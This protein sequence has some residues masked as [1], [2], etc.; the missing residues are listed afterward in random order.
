MKKVYLISI[1]LLSSWLSFAQNK[2]AEV[3]YDIYAEPFEM[4][5][6]HADYYAILHK[7]YK[8]CEK[9]AYT[10]FTSD[11][12]YLLT[13]VA[14]SGLE[15]PPALK[16]VSSTESF[17]L[18]DYY[19]QNDSIKEIILNQINTE[20]GNRND[21]YMYIYDSGIFNSNMDYFQLSPLDYESYVIDKSGN[22]FAC[23][24]QGGQFGTGLATLRKYNGSEDLSNWEKF[25]FF[26]YVY[27]GQGSY[28][29]S[30]IH[31][32]SNTSAYRFERFEYYQD[33]SYH[34]VNTFPPIDN[35][36]QFENKN[37][38]LSSGNMIYYLNEKTDI[39]D[40]FEVENYYEDILQEKIIGEKLFRLGRESGTGNESKYVLQG[41]DPI[42]MELTEEYLFESELEG[43]LLFNKDG[44]RLLL[45]GNI[46]D[47]TVM[48][49]YLLNIP[50]SSL[51]FGLDLAADLLKVTDY[52]Y[53]NGIE[54][55]LNQM[56]IEFSIEL[57]NL[58]DVTIN[59]VE[60]IYFLEDSCETKVITSVSTLIG[61]GES[62][63]VPFSIEADL[64]AEIVGED[65]VFDLPCILAVGKNTEHEIEWSNNSSCTIFTV[66]LSTVSQ[67][68]RLENSLDI[69][70]F[71]NPG[72]DE[73][74]IELKGDMIQRLEMT[75]VNGR[76]IKSISM[77]GLANYNWIASDISS[78]TYFIKVFTASG[79][80]S[81][82]KWVKL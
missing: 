51:N 32:F 50:P 25:Q 79:K 18:F 58:S 6:L 40:S 33:G 29:T 72:A 69:S 16:Y 71:P 13:M 63:N 74:H 7:T 39:L 22:F 15:K 9:Y 70:I 67:T 57:S 2:V 80:E 76:I 59:E 54:E 10:I 5:D 53:P 73:I 46:G 26:D 56:L 45:Y 55:G 64:Y 4:V 52:E 75:D 81:V 48:E 1:F 37:Y 19:M 43:D 8:N 12:E 49:E 35:V 30:K 61:P 68:D 14:K 21:F 38:F 3:C 41:F 23:F 17:V 77:D 60:L 11:H 62:I 31:G 65:F 47:Q 78:G 44:D 82:H 36:V 20:G 42:L 66:P 28:K 27:S 34:L 24:F